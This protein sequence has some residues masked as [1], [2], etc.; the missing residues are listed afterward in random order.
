MCEC[1]GRIFTRFLAATGRLISIEQSDPASQLCRRYH[2]YF[3]EVRGLSQHSLDCHGQ[4]VADF[5][6]RGVPADHDLSA[7]AAADV[8]AFVQLKSKENNRQSL[9]HVIAHLRALLRYCGDRGEALGG[10]HG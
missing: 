5:L 2:R 6:S 9:Q 4:T 8:E 3:T 7:V 1:T 10:L